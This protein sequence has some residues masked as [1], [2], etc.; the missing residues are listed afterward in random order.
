MTY[1]LEAAMSGDARIPPT[2]DPLDESGGRNLVEAWRASGLSGAAFCRQH[3]LRVQRLHYWR[4]RL[5]YPI[6]VVGGSSRTSVAVP[7]PSDGFVQLVVSTPPTSPNTHVDIVI[8]GAII[9]VGSG[10]DADLL[11]RVVGALG[12]EP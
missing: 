1:R 11:R 9:R 2:I 10:F 8:G 5:G 3:D 7:P 4:E 12:V 6:K